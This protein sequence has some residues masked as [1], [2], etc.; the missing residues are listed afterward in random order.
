MI[1]INIVPVRF[2]DVILLSK[3]QKIL[4]SVFKSNINILNINLEL[5]KFYSDERKQYYST[6]I[7][8]EVIKLTPENNDNLIILTGIDLYVPVLTYIFGEAQL[9]GKYSIVSVRRL[10][11][12]FYTGVSNDELLFER[13][14]KEILHELGHNFGLLHCLDWDCVMHASNDVEEVDIKGSFYCKSCYESISFN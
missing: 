7:L 11:E 9:K 5:N 14:V 10:H 3:I 13:T 12:E 4:E 8:S 6:Q 1:K 2:P